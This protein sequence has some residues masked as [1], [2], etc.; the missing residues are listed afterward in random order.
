MAFIICWIC[1]HFLMTCALFCSPS[2]LLI[3][4]I[5]SPIWKGSYVTW[6]SLCTFS[7]K[8]EDQNENVFCGISMARYSFYSKSEWIHSSRHE[9]CCRSCSSLEVNVN[10]PEIQL[11]CEWLPSLRAAPATPDMSSCTPYLLEMATKRH[12]RWQ[13]SCEE[14]HLHKL[15]LELWVF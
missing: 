9:K 4:N 14:Y 2:F 5:Q 6:H 7:P 15:Q 12:R 1:K 13:R 3:M 10:A 8:V 11:A